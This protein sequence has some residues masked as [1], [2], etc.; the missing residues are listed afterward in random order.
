MRVT[1]GPGSVYV[2]A[3]CGAKHE[4]RHPVEAGEGLMRLDGLGTCKLVVL[5]RCRTFAHCRARLGGQ[6]SQPHSGEILARPRRKAR[7]T[8]CRGC[9]SNLEPCPELLKVFGGPGPSLFALSSWA[10]SHWNCLA[11]QLPRPTRRVRCCGGGGRGVVDER[12]VEAALPLHVGGSCGFWRMTC[13]RG[14][15]LASRS[16]RRFW[17]GA[18][19]KSVVWPIASHRVLACRLLNNMPSDDSGLGGIA[20][21]RDALEVFRKQAASDRRWTQEHM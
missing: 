8:H 18:S 14:A 12:P 4:V 10:G 20:F 11:R 15:L 1:C 21:N 2:A 17:I 16:S 9:C 3:L 6:Q 5:I 13:G 19:R 7:P